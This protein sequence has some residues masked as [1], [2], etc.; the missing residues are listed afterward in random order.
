ML[1]RFGTRHLKILLKRTVCGLFCLLL[2]LGVTDAADDNALPPD[3][4]RIQQAGKLRVA[5]P[6]EDYPPF[7]QQQDGELQGLDI[8]L[9]QDVA[10]RLGVQVEFNRQA[11]NWDEIVDVIVAQQADVAIAALSRTLP[12]AQRVAYTQAYV[13]LPQALL[14][15]RLKLAGLGGKRPP[16][17]RLND[18]VVRIGTL[19]GSSYIGF[20]Q[21]AFPNA[22]IVP[23]RHWGEGVQALLAGE[24]HAVMFDTLLCKRTLLTQPQHALQIQLQITERPDPIAIAVNWRDRD[25]LHWLNIYIDTVKAEGYLQR[26]ERKYNITGAY[27]AT[28]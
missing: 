16:L 19:Q 1:G 24:I 21:T 26:L 25:L 3:I 14:I 12:R 9:A 8:E 17:L 6:Q 20:A 2:A 4:T 5:L 27:H 28:K 13:T 22:R 11:S 15:N 23:Y 10:H 7:F 18:H